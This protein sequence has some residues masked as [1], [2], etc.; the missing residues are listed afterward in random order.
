LSQEALRNI[1]EAEILYDT[2]LSGKKRGRIRGHGARCKGEL[3]SESYDDIINKFKIG[4]DAAHGV[5]DSRHECTTMRQLGD[6]YLKCGEYGEDI[7]SLKK[8]EK[9]NWAYEWIGKSLGMAQSR[10][11]RYRDREAQAQKSL[12]DYWRLCNCFDQASECYDEASRAI[13]DQEY[14]FFEADLNISRARL[15]LTHW[16]LNSNEETTKKVC[17]FAQAALEIAN[18][19]QYFVIQTEAYLI[20]ARLV[21]KRGTQEDMNFYFDKAEKL[22]GCTN[23]HWNERELEQVKRG[24]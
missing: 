3:K 19:C 16:E 1:E 4:I 12:G 7:G 8:A 22:I 24:V 20:L 11:T 17:D 14:P 18:R 13:L 10:Q 15:E 23:N 2:P 6:L 9:Y 5:S 21:K